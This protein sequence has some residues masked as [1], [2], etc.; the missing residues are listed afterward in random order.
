[1]TEKP[2]NPLTVE[3][4][5]KAVEVLRNQKPIDTSNWSDQM[6]MEYLRFEN[7]RAFWLNY[8][9]AKMGNE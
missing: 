5:R 8:H 3:D 2:S 7:P 1:M 6:K 9:I 4:I